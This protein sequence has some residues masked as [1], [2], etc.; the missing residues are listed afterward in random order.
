MNWLKDHKIISTITGILTLIIALFTAIE[1]GILFY[2]GHIKPEAS[3]VT[4][5]SFYNLKR[6]KTIN[7][8]TIQQINGFAYRDTSTGKAVQITQ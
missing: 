4:D 2:E 1:K 3:A 8:K 7:A 6:V 5:S